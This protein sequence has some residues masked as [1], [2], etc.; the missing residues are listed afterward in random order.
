MCEFLNCLQTAQH[1]QCYDGVHHRC[2]ILAI[3]RTCYSETVSLILELTICDL[4][5]DKF[6]SS[7]R[8]PCVVIE[9]RDIHMTI[10]HL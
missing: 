4:L 3:L 7:Y 6:H 1:A 10:S 8:N 2:N 5:I 9:N